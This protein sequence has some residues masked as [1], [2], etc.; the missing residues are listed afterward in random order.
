M[1]RR[2]TVAIIALVVV[3]VAVTSVGSYVLIRRATIST[4]EQEL[5]GEAEAISTTFSDRAGLTKA[6][7]PQGAGDRVQRRELH[8][9]CSS[10]SWPPT[11]PSPEHSTPG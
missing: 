3:T 6:G 4:A 11:A 1:R 7:V 8:L 2:L 10:C 9:A 5:A